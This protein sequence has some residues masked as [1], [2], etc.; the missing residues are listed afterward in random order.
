[1]TQNSVLQLR[2]GTDSLATLVNHPE[3]SRNLSHLQRINSTSHL[4]RKFLHLE[5]RRFQLAVL[6]VVGHQSMVVACILVVGEKRHSVIKGPLFR[7]LATKRQRRQTLSDVGNNS[8]EPF[9]GDVDSGVADNGL[10]QNMAYL[11]LVAPFI[12]ELDDVE[13]K[14]RLHNLR[15]LRRISEVEGHCSKGRVKR[16]TAL[17]V[18]FSAQTGRTRILRVKTGQR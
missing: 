2:H 16:S 9:Q 3:R 15:H 12:D 13:T 11:D 17:I 6:V 18:Q 5:T 4:R 1:M 7:Q 14:L 10:T 8:V